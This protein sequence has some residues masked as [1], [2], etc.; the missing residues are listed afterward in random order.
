MNYS[1]KTGDTLSGIAQQFGITVP[2]LQ[3]W[4]QLADPDYIQVGQVLLIQETQEKGENYV[5]QVGD[6]LSEIA[7]RFGVTVQQLQTWNNAS[8]S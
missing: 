3:Q 6:T 8:E 5:V 2:Q 1:V 4:N 7:L